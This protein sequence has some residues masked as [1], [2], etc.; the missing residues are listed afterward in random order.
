MPDTEALG[1]GGES[2]AK[3]RQDRGIDVSL[4]IRVKRLVH[5]RYQHPDLEAITAFLLD[6][7]MQIA[8]RTVDRIWFSGYGVDQYVYYAQAGPKKF[9]GGTFEVEEYDDLTQAAKLEG[10]QGITELSDAPGGC[11]S[12]SWSVTM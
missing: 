2:I 9:L 1:P 5:M 11:P 6:F 3:W 7:G 12:A 10:A 4:Q 8:H